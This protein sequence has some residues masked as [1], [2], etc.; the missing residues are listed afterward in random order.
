[1]AADLLESLVG[2]WEGNCWTS[3]ATC[4]K[5]RCRASRATA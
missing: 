2:S 5:A 3:S 1:M 4:T